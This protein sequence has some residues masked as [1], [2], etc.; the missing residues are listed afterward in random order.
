MLSKQDLYT[1]SRTSEEIMPVQVRLVL[2]R[3][4]NSTLGIAHNIKIDS[5]Y[6]SNAI[7]IYE[8]ELLKK[9]N[10]HTMSRTNGRPSAYHRS[11]ITDLEC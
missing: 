3:K 9:H 8:I 6:F 11:K 5:N 2:L 4:M 10:S 1:T 7:S